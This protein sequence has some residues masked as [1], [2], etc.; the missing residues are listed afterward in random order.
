MTRGRVQG[1]GGQLM[2]ELQL[3]LITSIQQLQDLTER[4][5][6]AKGSQTTGCLSI[7]SAGLRPPFP[8]QNH[9]TQGGRVRN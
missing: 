4:L 1:V 8:G 7:F 5:R 9:R 2:T 6:P 3:G